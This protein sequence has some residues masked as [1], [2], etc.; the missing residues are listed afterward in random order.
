[1]DEFPVFVEIQVTNLAS[2]QP[3]TIPAIVKER[4]IRE[5]VSLPFIIFSGGFPFEKTKKQQ[6]FFFP[7]IFLVN[8][9]SLSAVF[10][11]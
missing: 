5:D 9:S 11:L 10:L 8:W 6:L 1:M 7:L 2:R 4:E 3:C